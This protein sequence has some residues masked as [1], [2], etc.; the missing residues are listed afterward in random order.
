M[1]TLLDSRIQTRCSATELAVQTTVRPG[2]NTFFARL[3]QTDQPLRSMSAPG[4]ASVHT[5]RLPIALACLSLRGGQAW[6]IPA[7]RNA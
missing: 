2:P 3:D 7:M 6:Y 1:M 4:F 5:Y